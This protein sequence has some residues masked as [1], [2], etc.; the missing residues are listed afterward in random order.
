MADMDL[1]P[2]EYR[3][4]L[5]QVSTLKN[6]AVG[7]CVVG[8]IL[9]GLSFYWGEQAGQINSGMSQLQNKMAVTRSQREKLESLVERK[10]E[11]EHQWKLLDGLRGG[12][13]VESILTVIDSTLHEDDV[14]FLDWKFNRA[15]Q[16]VKVPKDTVETGY[17]IVVPRS[18][19][20]KNSPPETWE[21][22]TH[23]TIN[24][25]ARDHAAFSGFVQRLISRPEIAEVKVVKTTLK[26]IKKVKIVDFNIVVLISNNQG[27]GA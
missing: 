9:V 1:I 10:T 3:Y 13:T 18:D 24:G 11:L 14:W 2:K 4:W 15:G 5:W 8:A 7:V 19:A 22:Q 6:F 25:Q 21:I 26:Q 16:A 20:N 23:I 27:H 12:T 17:F